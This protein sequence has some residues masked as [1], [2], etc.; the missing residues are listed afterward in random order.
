MRS[1]H[2]NCGVSRVRSQ[3]TYDDVR[4]IHR[5][6]LVVLGVVSLKGGI[7]DFRHRER[8]AGAKGQVVVSPPL[9]LVSECCEVWESVLA[10]RKDVRELMNV[11]TVSWTLRRTATP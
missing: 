9:K 6:W 11:R 1:P 4:M 10:L 5:I 8:E 3:N 7:A 2:Q